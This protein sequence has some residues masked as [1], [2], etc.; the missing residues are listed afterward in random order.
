MTLNFYSTSTLGIPK[1]LQ[2]TSHS[3]IA[4][5]ARDNLLLEFFSGR[6]SNGLEITHL[7]LSLKRQRTTGRL[8]IYGD[9]FNKLN[10]LHDLDHFCT[11]KRA[12]YETQML[13]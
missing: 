9:K 6:P 7:S 4:A 8:V 2:E 11:A 1:P 5:E 13:T 12:I 3:S 10:K